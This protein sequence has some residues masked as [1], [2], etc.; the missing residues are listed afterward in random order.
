MLVPMLTLIAHAATETRQA[1]EGSGIGAIGLD[2]RALVFQLVNFSLL[3]FLL[4][5]FAYKPILNVL[6]GRRRTI[7]ESLKKAAAIE[8]AQAELQHERHRVIKEARRQAQE[9]AAHSQER[10]ASIV[11]AAEE[12]ARRQA[13][14]IVSQGHA[15]IA[16][17]A[18]RRKAE[19]K[20]ETLQLVAQA[21]E[22]IIDIKLDA[23]QD[24][25][26]IQKAVAEAK[27]GQ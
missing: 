1:A 15:Q 24:A 16:Q 6:Q 4:R 19:L 10:A 26:L 3:L 5:L 13:A 23:E 8:A 22:A 21:T 27:A 9:I 18:A 20:H 7:E 2:A 25:A 17:E 11:A 14:Q 12:E